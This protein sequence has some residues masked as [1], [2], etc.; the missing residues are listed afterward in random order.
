M[1]KRIFFF[2]WFAYALGLLP[3]F[4][5]ETAVLPQ[6]HALPALPMLLPLA[7][8]AVA[9]FEG[10]AAGAGFG[11]AVGILCDAVWFG[12]AGGM[13]LGLALLGALCGVVAQYGLMQNFFGCFLCCAGSLLAIDA[14]RVFWMLFTGRAGPDVLLRVA[15]GE[16]LFSLLFTPLVYLLFRAVFRRVGGTRLV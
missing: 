7:A 4:L 14:L 1:T 10:A 16:I 11:F 3:V 15:T 13:T 12:P 9:V 2:K 6:I 8:V 5:L